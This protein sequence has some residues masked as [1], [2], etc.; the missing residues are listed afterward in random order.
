MKETGNISIRNL[1][2]DNWVLLSKFPVIKR[3]VLIAQG[4][5]QVI[6]GKTDI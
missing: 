6:T 2:I 3:E 5:D 1:Q 4:S